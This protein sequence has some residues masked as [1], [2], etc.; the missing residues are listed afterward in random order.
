M[1]LIPST[2]G[3]DD[4]ILFRTS[5]FDLLCLSGSF[6]QDL[7]LIALRTASSEEFPNTSVL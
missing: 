6:K 1:V 3:L 2:P 7:A 4:G 5:D